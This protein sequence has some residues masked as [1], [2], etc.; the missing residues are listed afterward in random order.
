MRGI[1]SAA[2]MIA[3]VDERLVSSFDAVYALSA[4]AMNSAYF[5]AGEGWHA[6]SIY[7]D[8]LASRGFVDFRRVLRGQ[9]ALSL[10]YVMDTVLEAAKP[11]DYAAVLAS[12]IELH[13]ATSSVRRLEPRVFTDFASKQELKMVLKA[14][15]CVPVLAGG[16][17]A[18]SDDLL[19]DGGVLMGHPVLEAIED[20]CTH[21]VVLRT[22]Q[23]A[24]TGLRTWVFQK[25]IARHLEETQTGLGSR[26]LAALDQYGQLRHYVRRVSTRQEGPPFILDVPCPSL[27][28]EMTRF[29]KNRGHLFEG[30]RA[31]YGAMLTALD[32][33]P[34]VVY[35]RPVLS[36]AH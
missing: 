32:C 15:I 17:V 3:L 25:L 6:L 8:N 4:G 27:T 20:G 29:S 7:Y 28:Q 23:D 13:V 1:I 19:L 21:I 9:P 35:L 26:Y 14:S 12:P 11:L 36:D 18:Y 31:G 34:N 33:P 16:P 5:L 22:R 10:D 30:V 24:A 2:M